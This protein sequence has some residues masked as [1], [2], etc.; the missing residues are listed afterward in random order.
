MWISEFFLETS[1]EL[2]LSVQNWNIHISLELDWRETASFSVCIFVYFLK[3][4]DLRAPVQCENCVAQHKDHQPV[5]CM[6]PAIH[7][8][9][10]LA[11]VSANCIEMSSNTIALTCKKPQVSE[12]RLQLPDTDVGVCVTKANIRNYLG[13]LTRFGLNI[14]LRKNHAK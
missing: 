5:S 3:Q 6:A 4:A 11:S 1:Q 13:L 9:S 10:L 12:C 7:H 2:I 14:I 8:K